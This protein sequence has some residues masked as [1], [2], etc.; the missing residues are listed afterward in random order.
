MT[1]SPSTRSHVTRHGLPR[2]VPFSQAVFRSTSDWKL[3]CELRADAES[4]GSSEKIPEISSGMAAET[5]VRGDGASGNASRSACEGSAN[6]ASDNA[7]NGDAEAGDSTGTGK[8]FTPSAPACQCETGA[9]WARA[10]SAH[11][12]VSP[13]RC[14]GRS[15]FDDRFMTEL[16]LTC[17]TMVRGKKLGRN[18]ANGHV[19]DTT[20]SVI[21]GPCL[22]EVL[23]FSQNRLIRLRGGDDSPLPYDG[24]MQTL[25]R[26]S[27][28]LCT[29]ALV[30]TSWC[31]L[32]QSAAPA[33]PSSLPFGGTHEF[34]AYVAHSWQAGKVLGY[35]QNTTFTT[36]VGRYSYRVYSGQGWD[37]RWA[38]ELTLLADLHE[39]APSPDNIDTSVPVS[40]YG[41]GVSPIA[42]QF[43]ALPHRR[44]QPYFNSQGGMLFYNRRVLSDGGTSFMFT[45]DAGLG[46]NLFVSPRNA[47]NVG[48]RYEH[49]SNADIGLHNPGADAQLFCFGFSHFITKGVR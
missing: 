38:P 37:L 31:A 28:R 18:E 6:V 45:V 16:S 5:A 19:S 21:Q 36:V 41:G 14:I 1:D 20:L 9:V 23:I 44:V 47:V 48:F 11:N 40:S 29:S 42:L 32:G 2:R 17:T 22:E 10:G 30:A 12:S 43:V 15:Q 8:R 7:A 13:I 35:V 27:S 49:Q 26:L 39:P 4:M 33:T 34:S 46:V 3:G 25:T 24:L